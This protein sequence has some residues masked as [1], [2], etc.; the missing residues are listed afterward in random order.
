MAHLPTTPEAGDAV[1]EQTE[2]EAHSEHN[3]AST[4]QSIITIFTQKVQKNSKHT[5][6]AL[7]KHIRH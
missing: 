7:I 2:M 4:V 3:M 5:T 1:S 6:K